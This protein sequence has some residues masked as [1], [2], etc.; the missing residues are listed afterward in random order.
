MDTK[1]SV[2]DPGVSLENLGPGLRFAGATGSSL[3][4]FVLL[5]P[6]LMLMI[7]GLFLVVVKGVQQSWTHHEAARMARSE[8]GA[9]F[10]LFLFGCSL[11]FLFFAGALKL[12]EQMFSYERAQIIADTSVLSSLRIRAKALQLIAQRWQEIGRDISRADAHGVRVEQ[13]RWESVVKTA[14]EISSSLSGYQ[15]RIT[16]VAT[17]LATA[18]GME[19][20][21]IVVTDKSAATLGVVVQSFLM[22]DEHG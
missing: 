3:V 4:E 11:F 6:L 7:A 9:V 14:S 22:R 12:Q 17:V 16:A 20:D 18:Y 19:R 13:A 21:S 8:R 5:F 1:E 10:I 2:R 15:A